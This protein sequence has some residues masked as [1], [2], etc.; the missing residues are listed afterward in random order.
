MIEFEVNGKEEGK[1]LEKVFFGRFRDVP[2]GAFF[3]VLRKRDVKVNGVRTSDGRLALRAGDCVRVY[4][5]REGSDGPDIPVVYE[6]GCI[7][8]AEKPQGLLSEPDSRREG[9]ISLLD[10]MRLKTPANGIDGD[11][12][13]PELCHRLDRNTG[14]LIF[15]CKKSEYLDSV[16]AALNSRYYNKI[17]SV[18]V[19]GDMSG[20]LDAG[21]E[22]KT[23][24]AFLSKNAGQSRV[25]VSADPRPGSRPIE[26]R[27]RITG[28]EKRESGQIL[29][30]LE[31]MLVTGRTHQIRA[32]LA[33]LGF[34]IAGDGKYGRG[35]VNRSLGLKYQALW[36]S[37]YEYDPYW[38][39]RAFELAGGRE[40]VLRYLPHGPFVSVPSF[41]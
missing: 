24:S 36:A 20:V 10:T 8:V 30:S 26:T 14:G 7:I 9:E 29:T 23:F 13:G 21:G 41:R 6:N 12:N 35:S 40:E 1:A 38:D 37:R 18:I 4:L 11:L 27:L 2:P 39:R 15:L 33:F 32:H 25:S 17:Y 22:W 28:I 3:R 31:A 5:D 19:V 34:P 16:K